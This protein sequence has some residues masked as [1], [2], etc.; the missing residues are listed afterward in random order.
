MWEIVWEMA[1]I[2]VP[3]LREKISTILKNE[4]E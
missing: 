2:D 3:L 4:F 1:V